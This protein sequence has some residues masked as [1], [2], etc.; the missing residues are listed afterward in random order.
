VTPLRRPAR[1]RVQ[2]LEDLDVTVNELIDRLNELQVPGDSEV[3]VAALGGLGRTGKAI[4]SASVGFDWDAG[5]VI[6]HPAVPLAVHRG[7][8]PKA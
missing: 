5:S 1:G 4:A 8:G 2:Q 6:L 7:A 3:R